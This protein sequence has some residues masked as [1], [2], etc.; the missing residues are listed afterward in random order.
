[1]TVLF[2]WGRAVQKKVRKP[3]LIKSLNPLSTIWPRPAFIKWLPKKMGREGKW[4]F[5]AEVIYLVAKTFSAKKKINLCCC[6]HRS[7]LLLTHKWLTPNQ[8]WK[9]CFTHN[10]IFLS[11]SLDVLHIKFGAL[12]CNPR[13]LIKD[14]NVK[15]FSPCV[16]VNTTAGMGTT[17]RGLVLEE[18]GRK[19][20]FFCRLL[21]E[22]ESS[23]DM[24]PSY[25]RHRGKAA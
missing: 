4:L 21:G 11:S 10:Y 25:D 8:K 23:I 14:M 22:N 13:V 7:N 9:Y 6:L 5:E 12:C 3:L 15:P 19:H 20:F 24:G 17:G 16:L 1:M 2:Q 18:A